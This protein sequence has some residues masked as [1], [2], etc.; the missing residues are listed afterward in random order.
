M[1]TDSQLAH[2][3]LLH[4]FGS[5][6]E[7]PTGLFYPLSELSQ[8]SGTLLQGYAPSQSGWNRRED[9]IPYYHVL[10]RNEGVALLRSLILGGWFG[11]D[12]ISF[13]ALTKLIATLEGRFQLVDGI[14]ATIYPMLNLEALRKKAKLTK[15]QSADHGKFWHESNISH[16]RVVERELSRYDYDL[17]IHLREVA[18]STSFSA[19]I[20]SSQQQQQN[21]LSEALAR[22]SQHDK[23]FQW[24]VNQDSPRLTRKLTPIPDKP[25]QPAEIAVEVP[26]TLNP[27]AAAEEIT[28]LILT[29]LHASRQARTEGLL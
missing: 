29:L 14:E 6:E 12:R 18:L 26:G 27:E 28:A 3:Q 25:H 7:D 20:W 21:V 2:D 24:Y 16:V 5:L 17:V 19:A 15:N 10:G 23:S 11:S 8:Q 13:Y 4:L 9:M 1:K 22:Y